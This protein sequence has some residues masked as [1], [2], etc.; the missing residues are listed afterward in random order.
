MSAEENIKRLVKKFYA[1]KKSSIATSAKMD[2]KVLDGAL[3]EYEKSN[4][5]SM[6]NFRPN[7][8]RIIMK[9]KI[10]K[11][12]TAATIILAVVLSVTILN[13]SA[14][15]A[16]AIEQTIEAFKN[17]NTVYYVSVY[18][19]GYRTE[20]WARRGSDGKFL[21]G[22]FR[23]QNNGDMTTVAN[24]KQNITYLYNEKTNTV[25]IYNGVTVTTGSWLDID[26]YELL[27][28]EM[29]D[30]NITHVKN[31]RTGKDGV[32]VTFKV[33]EK[34]YKRSAG[35]SGVILFDVET[36]LPVRMTL[37]DNE[38]RDGEPYGEVT[39]IVY[40]P[41]ISEEIFEFEIPEGAT[42]IEQE[43]D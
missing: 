27:R 25:Y 31:K 37:W 18:R 32:S 6:A 13:H 7:I 39:E 43:D 33:P 29:E 42:V 2:K 24:D 22:D 23:E 19:A 3:H 30:V 26:F 40:D 9:T 35:R 12:A 8:W 36:K 1:A 20:N 14:S 16:W 28:D 15:P 10:S 21:M 41:D 11:L 17:V 4:K 5:A 34:K 38:N